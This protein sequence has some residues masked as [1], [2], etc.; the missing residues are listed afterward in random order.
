MRS[1]AE[2][3]ERLD[4][5]L[6][7]ELDRIEADADSYL[8]DWRRGCRVM[9]AVGIPMLILGALLLGWRIFALNMTWWLFLLPP[10]IGCA[11]AYRA[12]RR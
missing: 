11:A 8:P 12:Q 1:G 10:A 5:R 9:L 2:S 7:L 3:D 6:Q 4:A